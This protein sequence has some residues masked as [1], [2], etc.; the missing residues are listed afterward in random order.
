PHSIPSRHASKYKLKT[1]KGCS[2]RF[3]WMDSAH[4]WIRKVKPNE[5]V[6]DVSVLQPPYSN[7]SQYAFPKGKKMKRLL[8]CLL[9]YKE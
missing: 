6:G 1:H 8:R 9:P 2:D 3:K 4:L 7:R 5:G